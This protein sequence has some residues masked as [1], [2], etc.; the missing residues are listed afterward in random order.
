MKKK[1]IFISY[2]VGKNEEYMKQQ[3]MN[4]LMIKKNE[5]IS[6]I[7][8]HK[9]KKQIQKNKHKQNKK[10][11]KQIN[12]KS[13]KLKINKQIKRVNS[14]VLISFQYLKILQSKT[15]KLLYQRSSTKFEIKCTFL[16]QLVIQ[17]EKMSKK[18]KQ[19]TIKIRLKQLKNI[20][21]I[22]KSIKYN[23]NYLYFQQ[24]F[25]LFRYQEYY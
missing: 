6:Q 16:N 18:N 8:K 9:N 17:K 24:V 21:Q 5:K 14:F 22:K 25:N 20:C 11:Q 15:Y 3:E 4:E 13:K 23:Y 7:I 2:L 1:N 12:I 19:L 10:K